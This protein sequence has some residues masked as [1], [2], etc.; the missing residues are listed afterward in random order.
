MWLIVHLHK[1]IRNN[2]SEQL[3][4]SIF[5]VV[6]EG[7]KFFTIYSGAVDFRLSPRC[8]WD[9]SSSDI[10]RSLEWWFRVDVSG[11][12]IDPV[13][14]GQDGADKLCRN[15]ITESPLYVAQYLGTAKISTKILVKIRALHATFLWS[16]CFTHN[17]K[18][19]SGGLS[20]N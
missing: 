10:L 1:I 19:L 17:L 15:V 16:L 3:S 6:Q 8:R 11:Q 5:R 13:F 14:E 4:T 12:P 20:P 2:I 7:H 18:S 9:L